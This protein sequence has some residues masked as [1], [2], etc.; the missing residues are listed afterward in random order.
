MEVLAHTD[1]LIS[2]YGGHASEDRSPCAMSRFVGASLPR[3][4]TTPTRPTLRGTREDGCVRCR[5]PA[6]LPAAIP[7]LAPGARVE[8][9]DE[10]WLVTRIQQTPADGLLVRALGLVRA[11]PRPRS[12]LLH[13]PR[14]RRAAAA[15]GHPPRPRRLAGLPPQP[16]LPRGA[17]AQDA[18][19]RRPRSALPSG[20]A[21]SSTRSS[22]SGAPS[23]RRSSSRARGC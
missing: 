16:P 9:R 5:G 19:A 10:D 7:L 3:A 4:T 13:Q 22:T 21:S 12:D 23:R 17:P 14:R 20:I 6:P 1:Q 18:A 15:R 8:V 2:D 11:R